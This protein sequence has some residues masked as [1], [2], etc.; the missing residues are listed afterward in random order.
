MDSKL[1]GRFALTGS[2]AFRRTPGQGGFA[3][4]VGGFHPSFRPPD[5]F[6]A[7][8]R[9]TVALT[10]GDNPKLVCEAYLAIT[11]NTIQLGASAS[12][13]ASACGFSLDGHI[14]FDILIEPLF[15][16]YLAEFRA[17]V[18]LKRGSRNLFKV[19]VSGA[20]EGTVPLRVAG[21][22]TFEIL[23]CDFSVSF[24]KTLV[25]GS[26]ERSLP[27]LDV[28]GVLLDQI[29]DAR[30][31]TA[32]EPGGALQLVTLRPDRSDADRVLLHPMGNLTI[33]QGAVP[34]QPRPGPRPGRH[35]HPERR[36]DLHDHTGQHRRPTS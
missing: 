25:G 32:L 16:H 28:L 7:L 23:W 17:S 8:K 2:A 24:D 9:I 21:K 6:P 30:H 27:L 35:H 4:S 14:G 22:A 10:A 33:K 5:G 19:S 29:A 36:S 3:L 13:Y 12:L 20:L 11:A 18:Q 34:A 26:S 31:W 1:C 15:F